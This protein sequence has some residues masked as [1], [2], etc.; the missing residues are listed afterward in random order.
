MPDCAVENGTRSRE[1]KINEQNLYWYVRQ[2]SV[3]FEQRKGWF[4]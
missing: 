4:L 2:L 1:R 3:G